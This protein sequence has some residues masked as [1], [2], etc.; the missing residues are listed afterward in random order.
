LAD[1]PESNVHIEAELAPSEDPDKVLGA[2]ARVLGDVPHALRRERE[3][4]ALE[5]SD[6]GNLDRLR[7]QLRDRRVR[8][9]A[10]KRL[11][12]GRSGNTTT[13]MLNRQAATVGV[14][15][16]CDSEEESSLGPIF[17]TIVSEQLDR[18][19]EWLTDYP[20]A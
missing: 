13:I 17:L 6:P 12:A 18:V 10:R 15:A 7:D 8:G 11:L 4:I 3:S 5:S 14:I 19:I 2:L 16:L 20:A 1:V 9:A